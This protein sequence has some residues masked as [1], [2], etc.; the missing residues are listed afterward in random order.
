M[1][2]YAVLITLLAAFI[3]LGSCGDQIPTMPTRAGKVHTDDCHV[4]VWPCEEQDNPLFT[5]FHGNMRFFVNGTS[6]E[7]TEYLSDD[8]KMVYPMHETE[9]FG[10]RHRAT[11]GFTETQCGL[12]TSAIEDISLV[13]RIYEGEVDWN[14]RG[15]PQHSQYYVRED[16]ENYKIAKVYEDSTL[17]YTDFWSFH[18]RLNKPPSIGG[19]QYYLPANLD[20]M[21]WGDAGKGDDR[22]FL[23]SPFGFADWI[24]PCPPSVSVVSNRG[25]SGGGGGGSGDAGNSGGGGGGSVAEEEEEEVVEEEIDEGGGRRGGRGDR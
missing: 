13:T 3:A 24:S 4:I 17:G 21:A 20:T 16:E 14:Y 18:G 12:W 8:S 19:Y 22:E 2:R 5:I 7:F 15:D 6:V 10:N 25:N 23:R 11:F 1:S 9:S